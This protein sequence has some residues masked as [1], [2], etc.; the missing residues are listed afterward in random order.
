MFEKS[1]AGNSS[2][3]VP[4]ILNTRSGFF[5]NLA[6]AFLWMLFRFLPVI[7]RWRIFLL[8]T[9]SSWSSNTVSWTCNFSMRSCSNLASI[10]QRCCPAFS[11]CGQV[12]NDS[13]DRIWICVIAELSIFFSDFSPCT[14]KFCR[15]RRP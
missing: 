2:T 9:Q 13:E 11:T 12:S 15:F 8:A 5:V 4:L 7:S 3:S 14:F 10:S 1:P 6:K